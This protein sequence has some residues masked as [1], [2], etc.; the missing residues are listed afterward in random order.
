MRGATA[1]VTF[2]LDAREIRELRR[3]SRKSGIAIAAVAR[4]MTLMV[5][6]VKASE[7]VATGP[8]SEATARWLKDR[9]T[10]RG[11]RRAR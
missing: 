4:T 10:G 5:F 2:V 11:M 7:R 6:G 3:A 8:K 9:A 1:N